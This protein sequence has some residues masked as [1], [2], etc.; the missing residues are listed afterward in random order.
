MALLTP[1]SKIPELN[2][3][4]IL[5]IENEERFQ[6]KL[7]D[8]IV[9]QEKDVNVNVRLARKLPLP[10]EN[11][12]SRPRV[13]LVVFVVSLRSE[14]SLQAVESS[15]NY[16]A[17]DYY[18]GKVCFVVTDARCGTLAQERMLRVRRLAASHHC[19]VLCAEHQTE[20]GIA[21]AAMRLLTILKV[22]AGLSPMATTALY[23]SS[24]TRCAA[25]PELDD[26]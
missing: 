3:A 23:L 16:L 12:D 22:S 21:M 11:G 10:L 7:A 2:T 20:E 24:L 13:D 6:T 25:A 4:T 14:R 15:L 8:A 26:D 19:P 9:Q 1:Y 18:L 5:L 17:S